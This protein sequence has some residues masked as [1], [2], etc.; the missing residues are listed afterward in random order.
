VNKGGNLV[1]AASSTIS[2]AYKELGSQFHVT[3][4]NKLTSVI[5]PFHQVESENLKSSPIYSSAL[6][7]LNHV[8]PNKVSEPVLFN[9][10]AHKLQSNPMTFPILSAEWTAVSAESDSTSSASPSLNGDDI[11]L[12]SGFQALNNARVIISGSINLFSDEYFNTSIES[13]DK[14]SKTSNR[15]L[16]QE[17]TKWA[18]QEKSVLRIDSARHALKKTD[19]Q[20]DWYRIKDN[21]TYHINLSQYT[22]GIWTKYQADQVQL[23]IVMLDPYIRTNL[24]HVSA[25]KGKS[26]EYYA[27][28]QLPDRYGVFTFKV[29]Y[30]R[31]GWSYLLQADVVPIRPL[32]HNEYPRFLSAAYPYYTG[33]I[34][35]SIGFLVFCLVWL[36]NKDPADNKQKLKTN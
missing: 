2:Q 34:S 17:I 3:F 15:V 7:K 36:Y 20:L 11:Q 22:G 13:N 25:S 5:D 19:E 10:I 6:T 16:A 9:G 32:R 26:S 23:E 18:F 35:M 14:K 8:V 1:I 29:D 31:P 24:Q 21:I 12:V 30:K 27:E 4:D 33:A 28:L